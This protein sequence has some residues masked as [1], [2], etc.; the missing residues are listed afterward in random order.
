V[1]HDN[2]AMLHGLYDVVLLVHGLAGGNVVLV[3]TFVA[4]NELRL[5][6]P[7]RRDG[8]PYSWKLPS[9]SGLVSKRVLS[10]AFSPGDLS[11]CRTYAGSDF[12]PLLPLLASTRQVLRDKHL[13]VY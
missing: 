3:A 13:N 1:L 8:F 10:I 5:S 6:P 7:I 2:V 11:G 4:S 12:L 9:I